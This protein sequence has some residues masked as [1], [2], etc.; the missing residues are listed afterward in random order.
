MRLLNAFGPTETVITAALYEVPAAAIEGDRYA[1][2]RTPIGRGVGHRRLY[3]LDRER[4]LVPAGARGE[5][6][7]GGADLARGYLNDAPLT[8]ERFV[9]NPFSEQAGDRMYRTGDL[10]RWLP[11][12]QLEFLGRRD[13]Q[14]KIRGFRVELGEVETV[15][16]Q[17]WAISESVVVARPGLTTSEVRVIGT[18]CDCPILYHLGL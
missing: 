8:A 9:P 17:Y 1:S 14:V 15:L 4:Q 10:A 5:L 12:G 2:R 6:Y 11:E 3:V 18:A 13:Q 16:N 7:I